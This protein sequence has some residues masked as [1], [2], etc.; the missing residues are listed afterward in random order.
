MGDVGEEVRLVANIIDKLLET[1]ETLRADQLIPL[2]KRLRSAA[3]AI[4]AANDTAAGTK[5]AAARL[6]SPGAL[7]AADS[8]AAGGSKPTGGKNLKKTQVSLGFAQSTASRSATSQK[9]R[10]ASS[11]AEMEAPRLHVSSEV[12]RSLC[13]SLYN[14][15]EGAVTLLRASHGHIFVKKGDDMTSITNVAK[16]LIFPPQQIHY[17]CMGNPDAEVLGSSIALNRFIEDVGKKSAVLIFPVFGSDRASTQSHA[18]IA[19]IHVERKEHVFA[20]FNNSD[21]CILYF[22]SMFC[23][24]LM[25]RIPHFDQLDSFYDP[26]TQHIIAP[27]VP[28]KPVTLPGIRRIGKTDC[29]SIEAATAG[30]D[31]LPAIVSQL[32]EKVNAQLPEVLIRREVLPSSNLRPFAPGV[33]HMPSLLE[34]QA[35]VDNLQSC[36]RKKTADNVDLLENDRSTQEDLKIVRSELMSI[37]RQLAAANEKLRLYELETRDYKYEY[38]ALKSELNTYMDKLDRLH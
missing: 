36:W 7:H 21:E 12:S 17:R 22:A 20:P 23:G 8:T 5:R 24:E 14:L 34:I 3:D 28:Y 2:T 35:Y 4:A 25:S 6:P 9:Q 31:A 10:L 18:P 27:F 26:A 30:N 13:C 32:S 16:K 19:T 38:R 37:R 11:G 1:N 33:T 29:N 15:L